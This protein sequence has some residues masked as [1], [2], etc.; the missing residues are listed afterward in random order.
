QS[1]AEVAILSVTGVGVRSHT[2]VGVRMFRSLSQAGINVELIS[3][4]EM[5]VNAVVAAESGDAGLAVLEKAFA[6]VLEE[7]RDAATGD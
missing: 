4:S 1:D 5:K 2:G 7:C 6:D 3:T